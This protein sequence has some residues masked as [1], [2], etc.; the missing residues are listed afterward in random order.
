MTHIAISLR[1]SLLALAPVV[2]M[3]LIA[4][5]AFM[6]SASEPGHRGYLDAADPSLLY[7]VASAYEQSDPGYRWGTVGY[8]SLLGAE[9]YVSDARYEAARSPFEPNRGFRELDEGQGAGELAAGMVALHRAAVRDEALRLLLPPETRAAL[10]STDVEGIALG[11]ATL[12]EAVRG[13][14]RA[15]NALYF[16]LPPE[17]RTALG[18][19]I[20][21]YNTVPW[22]G[23]H[24]SACPDILLTPFLGIDYESYLRSP[25]S[26]GVPAYAF[27]GSKLHGICAEANARL[28]EEVA[29]MEGDA[30]WL[31]FM[32]DCMYW[33]SEA[34]SEAILEYMEGNVS[35][36][37]RDMIDEG[38][39]VSDGGVFYPPERAGQERQLPDR[40][41]GQAG[42]LEGRPF[43]QMCLPDEYPLGLSIPRRA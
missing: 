36:K 34:L 38:W 15:A 23:C 31:N 12:R 19:K 6:T 25:H 13:D 1:K 20:Y 29:W 33:H 16:A 7:S 27:Y 4:P 43:A 11:I 28:V 5:L 17:A 40:G 26:D 39:T 21:D 9:L 3:S 8:Y 22:Y 30:S 2:V 14:A 42:K 32:R 10:G 18:I 24:I 37:C 35:D 41:V